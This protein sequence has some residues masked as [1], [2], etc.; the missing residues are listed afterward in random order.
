MTFG[1]F[2]YKSPRSSSAPLARQAFHERSRIAVYL[3]S[4]R[5]PSDPPSLPTLVAMH[6]SICV[7][8]CGSLPPKTGECSR[9]VIATL[10]FSAVHKC[11]GT[12]FPKQLFSHLNS[13]RVTHFQVSLGVH[14][15]NV[16]DIASLRSCVRTPKVGRL[17][18]NRSGNEKYYTCI[19]LHSVVIYILAYQG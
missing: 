1:S 6:N 17:S 11:E 10:G 3:R 9:P 15:A 5:S 8:P 18:L 13:H 14:L 2:G 7:L 16:Q 12:F 4:P 19:L